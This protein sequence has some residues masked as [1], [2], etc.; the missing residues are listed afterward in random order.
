MATLPGQR[1]QF[2]WA[3]N[4]YNLAEDT[5]TR[6]KFAKIMAKYI[7]AAPLNGFTVEQVTQGQNYPAAEVAQ[8]L[9][10][11][12]SDGASTI[13]EEQAGLE[14]SA[15]VD[16]SSVLRLGDGA[17]SVY[18]Y[19]YRCSPDR[20]KIGSSESETVQRIA[21]QIGTSTPD[22]PVLMLEIKSEKCRSLERAIH[23][24]LATRGKKIEGGG[25]E[26]FKVTR[27]EVVEIYRFVVGASAPPSV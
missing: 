2:T 27:D 5:D 13:S 4:Q 11:P 1:A 15:A 10:D 22:K 26:W 25:T 24:I 17:G 21:A 16:T 19:G 3:L 14:V 8:F 23:A 7:I 18:A 9:N 6:I 20:L 12:S